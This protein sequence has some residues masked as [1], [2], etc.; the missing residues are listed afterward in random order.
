M[1]FLTPIVDDPYDF[2][3]IAAANSLSDVYAMGGDPLCALNIVAYPMNCLGPEVLKDILLGGL[4]ILQEAGI[5]LIGGHSIEDPEIKYGLAVTGTI[6]PKKV[7]RNNSLQR[8]DALVLTKPLG[9]GIVATAAKAKMAQEQHIKQIIFSMSRLNKYPSQ[10]MREFEVHAC[11]DIT[12][13]GLL[14]HLKEMVSCSGC[15][16]TLYTQSIPV[17]EGAMEYAQQGLIPGGAY[18]NRE[19]VQNFVQGFEL[20]DPLLSDVLV[21]PQTSGGLL[22]ALPANQAGEFMKRL[23]QQWDLPAAIIGEV[24]TGLE[25]INLTET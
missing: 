4:A 19:Y 3:R 14:G 2:G 7:I 15:M 22:I 1:D 25:G 21:D 18:R 13:F 16:V 17:V 8:G 9:V 12:G 5:P 23:S 20:I 10:L 11:T 6:H 24:F